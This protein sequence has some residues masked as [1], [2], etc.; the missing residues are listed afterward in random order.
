MAGIK[1]KTKPIG[2]RSTKVRPIKN[3]VPSPDMGSFPQPT[4]YSEELVLKNMP[5]A[6]SMAYR[7]AINT[8][9]PLDDLFLVACQG[10][11]KGC[12]RYNSDLINPNTNKPYAL[13][14]ILV[15]YIRGAM[16]HWLRD[17]G[18]SSGVKFPDRWRDIAPNVRKMAKAGKTLREIEELTSLP[19]EEI[20]EIIQAQGVTT[21]LDPDVKNNLTAVEYN[22]DELDEAEFYDALAWALQIAD[23]AHQSLRWADQIQIETAWNPESSWNIKRKQKLAEQ[24]HKQFI[25]KAR[26]IIKGTQYSIQEQQNIAIEIEVP[27]IEDGKQNVKRQKT[28]NNK[29]ILDAVVLQLNLLDQK[30]NGKTSM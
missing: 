23:R 21:L 19:A 2:A 22:I 29:T 10:L 20:E 13:S 27:I 9:M 18:H 26:K 17:K 11:I 12:R 5:L 6:K 28:T 7:M 24:Q 8:K 15:P 30:L 14:T 1:P 3:N 25:I 16:M 4:E